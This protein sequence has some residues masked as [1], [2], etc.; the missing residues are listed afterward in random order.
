MFWIVLCDPKR[1][2]KNIRNLTL[3]Y[4]RHVP[5]FSS[6]CETAVFMDT[7]NFN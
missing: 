2:Q 6:Y 4:W 5:L 1:F 3:N 7:P